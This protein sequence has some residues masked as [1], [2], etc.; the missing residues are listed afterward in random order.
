MS[1]TETP[2]TSNGVAIPAPGTYA[3]DPSHSSV[4]FVAKHLVVAKVRGGFTEVAGTVQIAEDPLASSVE[5]TIGTA[6]I[7]TGDDGRDEHLRSA[8][9]F[10]VEAHPTMTYRSTAVA[11][12]GPGRWTVEG[13]LTIRDVTRPVALDLE[14]NGLATDP[15]GGSR[16]IYSASTTVEREAFGLTWNQALETG[17]VLVG[18]QVRIELEISTVAS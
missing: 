6:S 5:V 14:L 12:A 18:K 3:I 2:R 10:D 16:A 11:A 7:H 15:W 17:G 4:E 8:D 9:F 13:E 1:I